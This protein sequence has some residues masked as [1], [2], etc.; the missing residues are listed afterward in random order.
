M[1]KKLSVTL[2]ATAI[3]NFEKVLTPADHELKTWQDAFKSFNDI[4]PLE[5]T[6]EEWELRKLILGQISVKIIFWNN[7]KTERNKALN[8]LIS[9]DIR[10]QLSK[11]VNDEEV[12]DKTLFSIFVEW[13]KS[14][15]ISVNDGDLALVRKCYETSLLSSNSITRVK[16]GTLTLAGGRTVRNNLIMGFLNW[17][18]YARKQYVNVGTRLDPQLVRK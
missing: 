1:S 9:K 10:T 5:C 16:E 7:K 6:P 8:D 4:Q 15:G 17:L 11:I 12:S 14:L 13:L 3:S 2:S 18:L